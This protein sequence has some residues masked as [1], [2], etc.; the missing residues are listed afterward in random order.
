[1]KRNAMVL[2]GSVVIVAAVVGVF[3][4]HLD[5]RKEMLRQ[6]FPTDYFEPEAALPDLFERISQNVYSFRKG[7]SRGLIV[8]TDQGLAVFDT[9]SETYATALKAVLSQRF[10]GKRVHWVFYS[11]HHL[12]HIR[13]ASVLEPQE[14]IGH[15]D[16]NA[17]LDDW[18]QASDIARVTRPMD[19]DVDITLGETKVRLLYMPHSHSST[20]YGFYV[21]A[22]RVVFA[23]DMM[24]RETL[25]P[26]GL[27]DWYY[28]GYVRALDRLI[29]LDAKDYVPTHFGRGDLAD[30]VRYR[31]FIVDFHTVVSK[32]VLA[33]GRSPVDSGEQARQM[34]DEAYS[35]LE[36]KYG[37]WHGF[38][39]MFVPHFAREI[40]GA[41]LGY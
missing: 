4:R 9:F 22:A 30:L 17:L 39:S 3:L 12:D 16:I 37:R 8:D 40:G 29:A 15:R 21:P 27:P 41:Y 11:H 19:G 5:L 2:V 36:P 32:T 18:P 14:I 38:Y 33:R 31:T 26:F 7:M 25:P 10:P 28:P 13:G 34:M 1:M 6:A 35:E 23:P 24:F 20:L